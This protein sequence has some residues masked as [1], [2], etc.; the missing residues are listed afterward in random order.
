MIPIVYWYI[1]SYSAV[2]LL[3]YRGS[4]VPKEAKYLGTLEERLHYKN[5]YIGTL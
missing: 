4:Q 2:F 3:V 5:L 1:D